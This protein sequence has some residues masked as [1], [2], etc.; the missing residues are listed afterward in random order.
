MGEMNKVALIVLQLIR[1]I[2]WFNQIIVIKLSANPDWSMH[3]FPL[4]GKPA[5]IF[6][7]GR[8]VHC[9]SQ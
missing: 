8:L 2:N 1:L 3:G 4:T 6:F 9:P 7:K 5:E